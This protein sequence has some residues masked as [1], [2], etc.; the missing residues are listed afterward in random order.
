MLSDKIFDDMKQA[1]RN[2]DKTALGVLRMLRSEI[3]YSE[4][5]GGNEPSD[6]NTIKVVQSAI[7]KRKVAAEQ[8]KEAGRDDL[9]EQEIAEADVL[10]L[11]LPK[12]LSE[13]EIIEIITAEA[14]KLGINKGSKNGASMGQLMKSVM[15]VVGASAEGKAV[16]N[17][18]KSFVND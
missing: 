11:Y 17:L 10:A 4:T 5:D 9:A 18:V 15:A 2:K 3:K 6:E 14:E 12:Q 8:Y 1:M 13:T 7:K 16:N